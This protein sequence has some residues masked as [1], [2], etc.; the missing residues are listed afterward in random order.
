MSNQ[1]NWYQSFFNGI[2]N[3]FWQKAIPQEYTTSEVEFIK[4]M[5]ELKPGS[6]IIDV[7][8]GYGRHSIALANEGH[9]LTA[10]DISEEYI[11]HLQ[12]ESNAQ[13][14]DL[15]ALKADML[16][17]NFDNSMYDLAMCLGNSFNYFS[18]SSTRMFISKIYNTLKTGGWF[19]IHSGAIAETILPSVGEKDWYLLDDIIYL[20]DRSYD[21]AESVLRSDY[22]FIENGKVEKKTAFHFVY[23]SGEVKRMLADAGFKDVRFFSGIT[24]ADYTLGDKQVYILAKK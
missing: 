7:P 4:R 11:E 17:Y 20:G 3:R 8:C 22:I 1:E 23:T 16:T 12:Q 10:L 14:L 21:V 19:I 5:T 9:L 15:Q 2:A 24:G 18:A 6:K 13:G